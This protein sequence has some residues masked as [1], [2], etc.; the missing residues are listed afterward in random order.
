MALCHCIDTFMK[1]R[2]KN[3]PLLILICCISLYNSACSKNTEHANNKANIDSAD[4]E[5]FTEIP[6]NYQT[7][8]YSDSHPFTGAAVIDIDNDGIA[9]VFVGGGQGQH[10]ALLRYQNKQLK[11]VITGTGLSN[12]SATYG[13]A[14]VDIDND[15]DTDLIV[16][17]DNGLYLYINQQGQ[18]TARKI[19]LELQKNAVPLAVAVSDIDQD[20]HADLYISTFINFPNF[21]SATFNDP[22]HAKRNILLLNNGDLSFTDITE[23]S[24]TAGKQNTFLSVFTDLNNDGWQDLV[25]AQNTGVVEIFR[26]NKNKTFTS[27]PSNSDFGFWMSLAVGDIDKDGDQ[28]LFF[29]NVGHSIPE[30]LLQGDLKE[31]QKLAVEWLLLK[32]DGNFK[33]SDATETYGL[34]G[35]GFAWGGVFEDLNLDG[36]LDLLVAQNY[37]KWPIHKLFKL[38]G[39]SYLQQ[40]DKNKQ[41]YFQ[42]IAALGLENPYYGQSPLIVDLDND[43]KLDVLWINMDGPV[44][45][46]LNRSSQSYLAFN[47]PDN[48]A[49]LGTRIYLETTQ[50]RSYTKEIVSN[51]GMLT[52]QSPD[53]VFGLKADEQVKSAIIIRPDGSRKVIKQPK[54]NSTLSLSKL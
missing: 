30:F 10:D 52:D 15:A 36:Q 24:K 4:I 13:S 33:F 43:A 20:G 22:E 37:I 5:K 2:I 38:S 40:Q 46:F 28:D 1:N 54:I 42:H 34:N 25:L 51:T 35:E 23:S 18:F 41:P 16:A 8:W 47:V 14:A 6:V 7:H 48:A 49:W 27:M 32:N 17:R 45:A 9:E 53:I 3:V 11:N 26:N 12:F 44:R 31:D 29:S 21:K 50:G 39:R 19:P